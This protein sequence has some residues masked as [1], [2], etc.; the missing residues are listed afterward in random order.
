MDKVRRD[1]RKGF[2]ARLDFREDFRERRTREGC[3][4]SS[5]RTLSARPERLKVCDRLRYN[6]RH[7]LDR[8][9]H[10]RQSAYDRLSETCSPS[11]TKSRPDRTS[12]MDRSR[13]RSCPHRRDDSNGDRPKSKDCFRGVGESYDNSHSFYGTGIN[14][15]YRYH[16]RDRSH[17]TKRGRDS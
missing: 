2:H 8:L 6:D 5:A 10:R 15:G 3:H 11:T 7:V 4:Y 9:G 12:S 13:G 16:Y 17:H 1:K 14:H